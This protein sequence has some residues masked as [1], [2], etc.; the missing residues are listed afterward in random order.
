MKMNMNIDIDEY[1]KYENWNMVRNYFIY[2]LAWNGQLWYHQRISLS[3]ILMILNAHTCLSSLKY[4]LK[5]ISTVEVCRC[6]SFTTTVTNVLV[7]RV[8]DWGWFV[9]ELIIKTKWYPLLLT[10]YVVDT[11]MIFIKYK[12]ELGIRKWVVSN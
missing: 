9:E 2:R 1:Q 8:T 12:S 7:R 5:L 3:M 11:F 6:S 4:K 10:C